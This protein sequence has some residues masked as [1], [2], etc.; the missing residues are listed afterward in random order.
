M[1]DIS[2]LVCTKN[3]AKNII[4]CLDSA[5][6]ILN[7]GAELILVDG[8]SQDCTL[9]LVM[10]FLKANKII[11]YKLLS[12]LRPG[13]YEAFNLAIENA[14][15]KKLFFLHSDDILIST[16]ALKNDVNNNYADVVFYGI[17][18]KGYFFSRVWHLKKLKEINFNFMNIPPHVGILINSNIY[19][20]IGNF[21][22]DFKIAGDFDWMLR[23]LKSKNISFKFS[24]EIIY[25]MKTG[26]TSNSGFNSEFKKF[27]ED[28][29]VLKKHNIKNPIFRVICKKL[30]KLSQYRKNIF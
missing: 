16:N 30:N 21:V 10:D 20:Q 8:S 15:R 25:N 29:T 24:N 3:S 13:L 19:H 11:H 9:S 6:D 7:D 14:S 4:S 28:V 22:T 23:L 17:R 27:L 2:L 26:G 5:L 18:I 1:L 12:Q